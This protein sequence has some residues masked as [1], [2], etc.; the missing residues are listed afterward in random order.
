[1]VVIIGVLAYFL[2][3][4]ADSVHQIVYVGASIGTAGIV[5][6]YLFSFQ[7]K[8]G[9][10]WAA[11]AALSFGIIIPLMGD[12]FV[13]FIVYPYLTG[14]VLAL[15]GYVIVGLWEYSYNRKALYSKDS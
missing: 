5:V 3:I 4:S 8:F 15:M 9:G 2:A 11:L 12:H 10:K 7:D 1:M 6:I 14:F 13:D